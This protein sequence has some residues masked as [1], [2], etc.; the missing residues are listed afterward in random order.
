MK[1]LPVLLILICPLLLSTC[2]Q[3]SVLPKTLPADY[4]KIIGQSAPPD[5]VFIPGEGDL[6]S[7][8]LGVS[9]EPNI[10]YLIY[11]RW[12][13]SVYGATYPT[14]Y[15]RAQPRYQPPTRLLQYNDPSIH[16]YMTHPAFSYYPVTGLS[17]QQIQDYLQW[18][19]DRMNEAILLELGILNFTYGQKDED[20]FNTEAYLY[21]QYQGSTRK[22]LPD[23]EGY[24]GERSVRFED[25][26]L[27]PGFRLPTEAEWEHASQAKFQK[28][29]DRKKCLDPFSKAA[30]DDPYGEN[31]YTLNWLVFDEIP[32]GEWYA[33][34]VP[35]EVHQAKEFSYIPDEHD[36]KGQP[37]RLTSIGDFDHKTYGLANMEGNVREWLMDIYSDNFDPA[38]RDPLVIMEKSGFK[39]KDVALVDSEGSFVEKDS[40]GRMQDFRIL[41]KNKSGLPLQI[42][43]YRSAVFQKESRKKEILSR[44]DKIKERLH[45]LSV[46]PEY[47]KAEGLRLASEVRIIEYLLGGEKTEEEKQLILNDPQY[48]VFKDRGKYY[49]E[50]ALESK[51]EDLRF[52]DGDYLKKNLGTLYMEW[53]DIE[54]F[55][56]NASN[57]VRLVKGGTWQEPGKQRMPLEETQSNV[58]VGFRCVLPYAGMPVANKWKVK[59]KK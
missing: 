23:E 8:Y 47:Y 59:W 1:R 19:T 48:P 6:P 50:Y 11:L 31:Y 49:L 18:K 17:W 25:G 26:I 34:A 27:L 36:R 24:G 38:I 28:P 9:E 33:G 42:G 45:Y 16:A 44:I 58:E 10:N 41:G 2:Q 21:G 56:A 51:R 13:K 7:F 32:E 40:T 39:T 35:T 37:Q 54:T 5:M 29:I 55:L 43:N 12:L 57:K 53:G 4:P 20:S 30:V 3:G 14:V 46:K 15:Q 22:N 52:T